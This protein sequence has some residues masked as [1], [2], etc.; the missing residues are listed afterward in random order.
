MASRCTSKLNWQQWI[1]HAPRLSGRKR[2][3]FIQAQFTKQTGA[4]ND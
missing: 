4:N 2:G 1:H 3:H